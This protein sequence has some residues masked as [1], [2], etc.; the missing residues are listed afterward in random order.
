VT[1]RFAAVLAATTLLAARAPAQADAPAK[2]AK[3]PST[4]LQGVTRSMAARWGL[5][6][7]G[8]GQ[9]RFL[10]AGTAKWQT[11]HKVPGDSL[12]R[13]AMDDAGR[14]LAT[15]E[16]EPH[17]HLFDT[18]TNQH[19]T[20]AKPPAPSA[21]FK[22]GYNVENL[23][24][25][26]DGSAAIVYMH[27]FTGGRSWTTVAYR[28]DLG[29]PSEPALLFRQPGYELHSSSRLAVYALPQNEQSACEDNS[30]YPLG[31][32][33]GW[34]ISGAAAT[35]RILLS[36]APNN[37]LSRVRPVWGSD[38]ER[39]GV[40]IDEHPRG[41]QLLRWHAGEA[42]AAFRPLAPGPDYDTQ[43]VHLTKSDDFI[44]A[45][46]TGE[47]GL[48]IRRHA[49]KGDAKITA[50]APLPRRTP[51]DHPLFSVTEVI[52]RKNGGLVVN[53]GEYL[54]LLPPAGPPRRLDLRSLFGL[55]S[56]FEGQVVYVPAPEGLWFGV[57]AASTVDFSYLTLADLEARAQPLP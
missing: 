30:C 44:E 38:D 14:L 53:W 24:F 16:K 27:G 45:W 28:Y 9:L 33:I 25:T 35:K 42:N 54:V 4:R 6:A 13:V 49:P 18:K 32:I 22:Y 12:Y 39:V 43:A 37:K 23:Y 7:K 10:P 34:E 40:L 48:E 20:F 47:R 29:R 41:R 26:K 21:E 51:N 46:L 55:R 31:A 15:W 52:D 1:R 56:E 3:P 57:R 17:F 19:L 8:S 5:V 50:L 36:G 2:R 11:L